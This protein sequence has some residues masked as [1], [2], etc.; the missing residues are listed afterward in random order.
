MEDRRC[1]PVA[2]VNSPV[3][4]R[5]LPAG[6]RLPECAKALLLGSVVFLSALGCSHSPRDLGNSSIPDRNEEDS[7][8]AK[9]ES[10][11]DKTEVVQDDESEAR[12]AEKTVAFIHEVLLPDDEWK[13]LAPESRRYA[14]AEWDLNGDGSKEILFTIP[15]SDFCGSGGCDLWVLT[16][17]GALISKTTVVDFPI[18]ISREKTA[19]WS[20]LFTRSNRED[21]VLKY[22]GSGYDYNASTA[23]VV[24]PSQRRGSTEEEVLEDPYGQYSEF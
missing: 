15:T 12:M 7:M 6:S 14:A 18:G 8:Y 24:E 3:T 22:D 16:D 10:T 4:H 21:H 11:T 9:M 1:P 17:K 23:G 19:G 20:D 2:T 5:G 13:T